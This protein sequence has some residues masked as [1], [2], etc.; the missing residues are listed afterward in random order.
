MASLKTLRGL[1][2]YYTS[3]TL[4]AVLMGVL[5][6]ALV[7][8]YLQYAKE[9]TA[10]YLIQIHPYRFPFIGIGLILVLG[11]I[12]V[13]ILGIRDHRHKQKKSREGDTLKSGL[14]ALE[15]RLDS[16]ERRIP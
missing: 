3:L 8:L 13:V 15:K 4:Y 5:S 1:I 2:M 16:I 12:V 10:P 7:N 9:P 11:A 14:E 6:P